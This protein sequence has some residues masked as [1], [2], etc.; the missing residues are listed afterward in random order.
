M[1]P[2]K[3][4]NNPEKFKNLWFKNKNFLNNQNYIL[5]KS[6]KKK[7][8]ASF[9]WT[10]ILKKVLSYTNLVISIIF[11]FFSILM[12]YFYLPLLFISIL[13]FV[14]WYYSLE[15]NK[16]EWIRDYFILKKTNA[17]NI[18]LVFSLFLILAWLISILLIYPIIHIFENYNY[19]SNILIIFIISIL[20]SFLFLKINNYYIR[21]KGT[22]LNIIKSL[23]ILNI[24]LLPFVLLLWLMIYLILYIFSSFK[25]HKIIKYNPIKKSILN[26][27][28]KKRIF[29]NY[30]IKQK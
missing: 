21:N 16:I 20:Y 6:E 27:K 14:V 23:N 24:L 12:I 19:P 11:M 17:L 22:I 9:L 15:K 7:V 13:F 8:L 28:E 2:K 26:L 18:L 29:S 1:E 4:L 25:K 10:E 3:V 30:E 5:G